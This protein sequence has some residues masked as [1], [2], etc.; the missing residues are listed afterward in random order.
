MT[1]SETCLL[2]AG[3]SESQNSLG[4]L[5]EIFEMTGITILYNP[6]L[7]RQSVFISAPVS[8]RGMCTCE[9]VRRMRATESVWRGWP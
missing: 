5:G 1:A 3:S 8:K 4:R 6:K 9:A 2:F 7:D